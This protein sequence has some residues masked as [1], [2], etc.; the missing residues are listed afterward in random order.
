M[1]FKG[2][3]IILLLLGSVLLLHPI[4]C[5]SSL[6]AFDGSTGT[7]SNVSPDNADKT[8]LDSYTDIAIFE[9]GFIAVGSNGQIDRISTTGE[10][11][12]CHRTPGARL[13]CIL[14]IENH[15]IAA[16]DS[17]SVLISSDCGEFSKINCGTDRDINSLSWFNNM[18]IAGANR[19][20][21]LIGSDIG[22]LKR[23]LLNLKGDIVSLSANTT[24]CYGVT[25]TGEIIHSGDGKNWSIFDFNE[26]Y[27]GFYKSCRFKKVLVSENQ[28]SIIGVQEDGLPVMFYSSRGTVWTQRNLI[29]TDN[30]GVTSLL[31]DIPNDIF[32]DASQDRFILVCDN[33]KVMTIPGCT[34]CNKLFELGTE[35]LN[36]IA[37]NENSLIVAGKNNYIKLINL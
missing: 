22:E 15:I 34:H 28:I 11:N 2:H 23:I 33:G 3:I 32:Y 6:L 30:E 7:E 5:S 9:D 17:G 31:N 13:N 1:T 8:I 4:E 20:E 18:V 26:A 37:R 19:G 16:G 27:K 12:N 25:N 24:H 14:T 35:N 21:I 36:C 10:I 29:Y